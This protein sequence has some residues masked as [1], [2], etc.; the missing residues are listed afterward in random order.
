M[1]AGAQR[2]ELGEEGCKE[3]FLE[4]QTV[5][6]GIEENEESSRQRWRRKQ[7]MG[8]PGG[9]QWERWGGGEQHCGWSSE[10]ERG[11]V[12]DE[13]ELGTGQL[14]Q[15]LLQRPRHLLPSRHPLKLFAYLLLLN[16]CQGIWML[17][18][19][20]FSAP[21]RHLSPLWAPSVN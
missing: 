15:G 6:E 21:P 3:D 19:S 7:H 9:V 13:V 4:E 1:P 16:S 17:S 20:V 2:A 14:L 18:L 11:V 10:N 8:R 12:G 5:E